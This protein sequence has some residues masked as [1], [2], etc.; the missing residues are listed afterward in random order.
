MPQ[1]H[2]FGGTDRTIMAAAVTAGANHQCDAVS[3][4]GQAGNG[5]AAEGFR[6]IR[7]SHNDHNIRIG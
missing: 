7:M 4:P 6:I 2:K 5:A 3:S 1:I